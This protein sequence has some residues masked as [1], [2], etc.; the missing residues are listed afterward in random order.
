MPA[1]LRSLRLGA[2]SLLAV[3]SLAVAVAIASTLSTTIETKITV[4]YAGSNDLGSPLFRLD[5]A[6]QP[7]ISLGTGT[8]TNQADLMF[9]DSRTLTASATENLDMAGSL[10]DPLGATL[11]FATIKVV[12]ICAD[13]ANTNNVL[14]GGAA[15][16]GLL[17]IFDDATDI[18]RVKPG[19]CFIWIAPKTGA[20]VTAATG[21]ILKVANSSSGTSVTYTVI[22]IG[23]SA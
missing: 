12:K 19:G 9:S 6:L 10:T 23:T 18:V 15:S 3:L 20:T 16:L 22:I 2:F 21:D 8:G 14:V 13:A 17:G 11:T 1:F 4:N 7:A 5:Q